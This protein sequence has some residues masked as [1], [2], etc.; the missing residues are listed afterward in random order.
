[1]SAQGKD[2]EAA[3]TLDGKVRT[4]LQE[5]E[6]A[7]AQEVEP[8]EILRRISFYLNAEPAL[9]IP[10]IDALAGVPNSQT[11]QLLEEM[12]VALQDKR[13]IK[14]IKRTLYRFRQKGVQWEEKI[15]R[16]RPILRPPQ[17]GAPLGY[18]GALDSTG[19]RVIIV[20]RP[21]PHGGTR[22]Y[23]S[24]VSDQEGILRLEVSD[25]T[26]KGL[27][28]FVD[29]SLSSE[30]FPAVEAP[31]GYCVHLLHEAA[32]LSQRLDKPLPLGY[33]DAE[34][35][36]QDVTVTWDGSGPLIYQFLQEDAVKDKARLLKESGA[37][38]KIAPFS[39]W[40]LHPDD[41]RPYA[42]AINEAEKSRIVLAPQ[43]KDARLN[44]L[45]QEALQGLFPEEKRLL[46]KRRL[47]EM[48]Y[49]LWKKGQEKEASIAVSAAIDLQT[50][51]NPIDP[52]PFCW[53]LLLK[54]LYGL[55]ETERE[56]EKEEQGSSL[57]V[58][59]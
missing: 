23:F 56:E 31:G 7:Q 25:L 45:Y 6:V 18:V 59:P 2:D 5:V 26:T 10:V 8:E 11:A 38:H 34:R 35:G 57:I 13:A 46:W 50:P 47:E 21:R 54:S 43:Q 53:N 12:K 17:P 52:N 51:F 1:M 58:T 37:L 22:V 14:A 28:E 3:P 24:I 33:G 48:A 9:A 49:I 19:S 27:R 32:E 29:N 20:A 36:L 16:E 44:S 40:F 42:E 39:S 55:L 30:E 15:S 41:V 4:I